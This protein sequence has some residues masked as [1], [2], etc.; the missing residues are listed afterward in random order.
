VPIHLLTREAIALYLDSLAA[1]R[2]PRVSTPRPLLRSDAD[3]VRLADDAPSTREPRN[4]PQPVTVTCVGTWVF[5]RAASSASH[6]LAQAAGA[7]RRA[8]RAARAPVTWPTPEMIARAPL[9]TDEYSNLF[10]V[11][12]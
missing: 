4:N 10:R 12:R 8:T 11:L 5:C 1:R 9:W 6:A 2:L 3:A 7:R